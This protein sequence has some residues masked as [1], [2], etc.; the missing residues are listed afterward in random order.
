MAGAIGY[1]QT[2]TLV[3]TNASV[4]VTLD[5]AF[6]DA[7]YVVSAEV[8]YQTSFWITNKTDEQFVFNVGTTN[9]YDQTITF[10]IFHE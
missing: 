6:A 1:Y 10:W 8:P 3:A 2:A 9:A 5:H 7:N 4:T